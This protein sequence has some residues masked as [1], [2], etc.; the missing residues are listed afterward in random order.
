[1]IMYVYELK[2][3][4]QE[5]PTDENGKHFALELWSFTSTFTIE[6]YWEDFYKTR[7]S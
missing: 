5:G 2:S 4:T 6:K 7:V 3:F 1:M